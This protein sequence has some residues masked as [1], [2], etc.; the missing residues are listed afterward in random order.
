MTLR[1]L[2]IFVTV[3]ETT[4]ITKA[5]E[6]LHLAQPSVSLAISELE[7]YYGIY[8]FDRI[9]RRLYITENGKKFYQYALHIVSL[10]DEMEKE[11]KNW[12][13][14][15]T[16]RI[17]SSITIGNFYLPLLI[18]EFQ[19]QYPNI[20]VQVKI[21]NTEKIESFLLKNQ[22]DFALVERELSHPKIAQ[23]PFKE[24][25]LIFICGKSHPL[26]QVKSIDINELTQFDFLLREKGSAGREIFDSLMLL[27]QIKI[28]PA[29]ESTSTQAIVKAVS[30]GLGISVLP[31]LLVKKDLEEEN[32]FKLTIKNITLSRKLFII[33]H[34][35]KFLTKSAKTFI[36]LC[37]T[38][39]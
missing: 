11:I 33:F 4:S 32:I 2:K 6:I 38:I 13:T 35:N 26:Y 18:K 21:N 3:Y 31:Y 24:D 39:L 12:D 29:W 1:H 28:I 5:S 19:K 17:G 34:R 27:Y 30:A 36:D 22:I 14:I 15:G 16:L 10:L 25:E 8:L 23:I 9:S 20:K 7:K 37:K